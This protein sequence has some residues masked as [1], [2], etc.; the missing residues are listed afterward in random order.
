MGGVGGM[1]C[2]H[3][4]PASV[5]CGRC[6]TPVCSRGS[7]ELRDVSLSTYESG[8]RSLGIV[9]ALLVGI[10]VVFTQLV[11]GL[12]GT[13]TNAIFDRAMY[14]RI[15]LVRGSIL[16]GILL[17]PALRLRNGQRVQLFVRRV[18]QRTVCD[19]C[20][21][22]LQRQRAIQLAIG[23]VGVV[24]VLYGVYRMY[25]YG[26]L[27]DLWYAGLGAGIGLARTELTQLA[28][29]LLD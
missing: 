3:G 29:R 8:W 11:P 14:L 16:L 17:V 21:G 15:G 22:H 28:E 9:V 20:R 25:D 6:G 7:D 26:R 10:P 27:L 1:T 4:E 18:G 2:E 12:L 19:D 13:L 5:V 23:L 24:V